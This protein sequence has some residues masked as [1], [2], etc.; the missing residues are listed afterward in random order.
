MYCVS[1]VTVA[2]GLGFHFY[3]KGRTRLLTSSEGEN[4][5]NSTSSS[6]SSKGLPYLLTPSSRNDTWNELPTEP[7]P[8]KGYR[9]ISLSETSIVKRIAMEGSVNEVPNLFKRFGKFP[10]Q[11]TTMQPF[12][13][14]PSTSNLPMPPSTNLPAEFT[15]TTKRDTTFTAKSPPPDTNRILQAED[16]HDDLTADSQLENEIIQLAT[17][18]SSYLS[19]R[20]SMRMTKNY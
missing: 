17:K 2:G 1:D 13:K 4:A 9:N 11:K 19:E 6:H 5:D 3:A 7:F 18:N 16:D 8:G 10:T 12:S 15:L 20:L 14:N